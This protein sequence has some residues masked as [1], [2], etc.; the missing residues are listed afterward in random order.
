MLRILNEYSLVNPPESTSE[1]TPIVASPELPSRKEI[2]IYGVFTG[3][4]F[5]NISVNIVK[6]SV[7]KVFSD[8]FTC[9][10][11]AGERNVYCVG[12]DVNIGSTPKDKIIV[13]RLIPMSIVD[14]WFG[15]ETEEF[16]ALLNHIETLYDN[17]LISGAEYNEITANLNTTAIRDGSFPFWILLGF[18]FVSPNRVLSIDGNSNEYLVVYAT[19]YSSIEHPQ[20][21]NPD[22]VSFVESEWTKEYRFYGGKW[23]QPNTIWSSK[24]FYPET[25]TPQL[26]GVYY[27]DAI[28]N[29]VF[30]QE[31]AQ[32]L[33]TNNPHY[34]GNDKLYFTSYRTDKWYWENG[35]TGTP[36]ETEFIFNN[37]YAGSATLPLNKSVRIVPSIKATIPIIL[38]GDVSESEDFVAISHN[39]FTELDCLYAQRGTTITLPTPIVL[40]KNSDYSIDD[41]ERYQTKVFEGWFLDED[42]TVPFDNIIGETVLGL[43]LYAKLTPLYKVTINIT[44]S[45][46]QEHDIDVSYKGVPL[47]SPANNYSQY[48]FLIKNGDT[49]KMSDILVR[50][51]ADPFVIRTVSQWKNTTTSYIYSQDE[52]V[53]I[54]SD[55]DI[56]SYSYSSEAKPRLIIDTGTQ[57]I[58]E[59][60]YIKGVVP[61]GWSV[62]VGWSKKDIGSGIGITSG[63]TISIVC[64]HNKYTQP[65]APTIDISWLEIRKHTS[66]GPYYLDHFENSDGNIT[67]QFTPKVG[68]PATAYTYWEREFSIKMNVM[69]GIIAL[70][71]S[72]KV[73]TPDYLPE[74]T[75]TARTAD[76][77]SYNKGVPVSTSGTKIS[78]KDIFDNNGDISI[79]TGNTSKKVY[80]YYPWGDYSYSPPTDADLIILIESYFYRYCG[81]NTSVF[82]PDAKTVIVNGNVDIGNATFDRFNIEKQRVYAGMSDFYKMMLTLNHAYDMYGARGS[83][84]TVNELMPLPAGYQESIPDVEVG[85]SYQIVDPHGYVDHEFMRMSHTYRFSNSSGDYQD[86]IHVVGH[87]GSDILHPH[88]QSVLITKSVIEDCNHNKS[89]T[90]N[91]IRSDGYKFI[92]SA[93]DYYIEPGR[94]RYIRNDIRDSLIREQLSGVTLPENAI[95]QT[96]D[97]TYLCSE[98]GFYDTNNLGN[99]IDIDSSAA[100]MYSTRDRNIDPQATSDPKIYFIIPPV[101]EN[102]TYP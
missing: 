70:C 101:T 3:T 96:V 9:E 7:V 46:Y 5:E 11:F 45:I 92:V 22:T 19:Q 87:S 66:V 44:D 77:I 47:C 73:T 53:V 40:D 13:H 18:G 58:G 21:R 80:I 28:G 85:I 34:I 25:T 89:T 26:E 82:S 24:Q 35:N 57:T 30:L 102:P 33:A 84:W 98:T 93:Y 61:S 97:V 71:G 99:L 16:V 39:L 59:T 43:H 14:E 88:L 23:S 86:G 68:S 55:I 37:E 94:L 1:A 52:T 51:Y 27:K 56:I 41:Y 79:H 2:R 12:S 64:T 50:T 8:S 69:N 48:Q 81:F 78:Q 90:N 75:L 65:D 74:V 32:P 49:L 31:G 29:S 6:N 10:Q 72:D 67:T 83:D 15:N 91:Y 4:G 17:E 76:T 100:P 36:S 62:Y 38:H 60:I 20:S 42:C 54:N 95:P 63:D